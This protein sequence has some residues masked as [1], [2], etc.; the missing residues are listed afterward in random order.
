MRFVA[1]VQDLVNRVLAPIDL[2]VVRRSA[3]GN[4]LWSN[5]ERLL[6]RRPEI[7]FDV[8]ANIGQTFR[9]VRG[10]WPDTRVI[11]FEPS[12]G[13]FDELVRV[14]GGDPLVD[15]QRIA[16]S[17]VDGDLEFNEFPVSTANS[18]LNPVF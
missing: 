6:G 4:D 3:M 17:D 7:V 8:G 10:A 9:A 5:V 1:K 13:P 11:C 12:A 2:R 16:L 14:V 18:L 15:T